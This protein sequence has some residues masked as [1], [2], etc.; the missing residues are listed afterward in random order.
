MLPARGTPP[1]AYASPEGSGLHELNS[2]KQF[3]ALFQ[4]EQGRPRLVLLLSPT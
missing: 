2:V 1:E 4:Q 3:S